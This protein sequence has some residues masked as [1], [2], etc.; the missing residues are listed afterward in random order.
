MGVLELSETILENLIKTEVACIEC[1][2]N[3]TVATSSAS[4]KEFVVAPFLSG[5]NTLAKTWG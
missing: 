4:S 5:A 2:T 1:Q 3:A